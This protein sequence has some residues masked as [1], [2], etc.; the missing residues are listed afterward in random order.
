MNVSRVTFYAILILALSSCSEKSATEVREM[1]Q[2]IAS[3]VD[4]EVSKKVA[5]ELAKIQS[6]AGSTELEI[7]PKIK[8]DSGLEIAERFNVIDTCLGKMTIRAKSISTTKDNG[9]RVVI[10]TRPLFNA[11]VRSIKYKVTL[12]GADGTRAELGEKKIEKILY[13]GYD[14]NVVLAFGPDEGTIPYLSATSRSISDEIKN[15]KSIVVSVEL[16]GWY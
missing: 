3:R 12:L 5:D 16:D 9:V 10:T 11:N 1:S 8:D 15:M 13:Q 4:A 2:A 7:N 14:N 6:A